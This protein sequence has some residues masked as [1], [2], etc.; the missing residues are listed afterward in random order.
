M[1]A[2]IFQAKFG[3]PAKTYILNKAHSVSSQPNMAGDLLV[4]NTFVPSFDPINNVELSWQ[5]FEYMTEN[6][7]ALLILFIF[8]SLP[9]VNH[10]I[11]IIL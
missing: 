10:Y 3:T 6:C 4:C 2:E 7:E 11:P 9:W 1:E 5:H 8:A